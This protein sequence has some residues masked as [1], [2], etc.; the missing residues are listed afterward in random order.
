MGKLRYGN[1]RVSVEMDDVAERMARRAIERAAPGILDEIER[2]TETVFR[3]AQGRWPKGKNPRTHKQPIHSREALR[4]EYRISE[5]G[6]K[7]SGHIVND[8]W[9]ARYV[10][11]WFA[12]G[13][14][15]FA[16]LIRRPM[17]AAQRRLSD[18]LAQRVIDILRDRE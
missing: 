17:R 12:Q 16:Y 9:W 1:A 7:V 10:S 6:K 15:A 5:D 11:L 4:S 13:R 3:Q 18:K 8:A 2:E 14:N